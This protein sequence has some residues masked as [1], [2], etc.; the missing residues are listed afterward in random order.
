MTETADTIHGRLLEAVHIS[1]YSFERAMTDLKWLLEDNRWQALMGGIEDPRRFVDT[2]DFS[3][4]NMDKPS[5][6]ELAQ[7]IHELGASQRQ[8]PGSSIHPDSL[9]FISHRGQ[10]SSNLVSNDGGGECACDR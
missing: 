4:F 9:G 5:R 7:M 2:L 10:T 8:T 1:G 6:K 3:S